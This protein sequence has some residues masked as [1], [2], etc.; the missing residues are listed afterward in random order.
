M[1][2]CATDSDWWA[3]P[4]PLRLLR[5]LRRLRLLRLPLRLDCGPQRL[6]RSDCTAPTAPLRLHRSDCTAPT[7]CASSTAL[8]ILLT[9]RRFTCASS[10]PAT[11]LRLRQGV[12]Y[13]D[14]D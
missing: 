10:W 6:H 3:L 1:Q 4:A 12:F 7:A 2:L 8:L 9:L 5:F 13:V 11:E 14:L